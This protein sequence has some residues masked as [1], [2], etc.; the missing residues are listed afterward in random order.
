MTSPRE[1]K[2]VGM[3]TQGDSESGDAEAVPVVR[4]N[5]RL[6]P[7][8]LNAVKVKA[9]SRGIPYTRYIRLLMEQDVARR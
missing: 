7:R 5:F 1:R 8:L 9:R 3:T 4:L 2:A 6:P